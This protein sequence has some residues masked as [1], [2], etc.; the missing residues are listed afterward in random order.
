M[1]A[2]YQDQVTEAKTIERPATKRA[3]AAGWIAIK[4]GFEGWP[5]HLYIKGGRYVWIEYK[6]PWGV[7]APLQRNKIRK[8]TEAGCEAYF[9][10]SV[11][12][13]CEILGC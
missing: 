11:E 13:A 2:D 12:R 8:L 9:V 1:R 4:I 7:E 6:T 5:D 3:R 10:D